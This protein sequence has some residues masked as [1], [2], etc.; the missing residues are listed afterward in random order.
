MRMLVFLGLCLG[1]A[2]L[3][4]CGNSP[5]GAKAELPAPQVTVA[6]PVEKM[7]R[8]YEYATGRFVPLES[9]EVRARVS[10]YL[11][12][13]KFKPGTEVKKNDI[14]FE[15]D[16]DPFK[17]DLDKAKANET[18]A[19]ADKASAEADLVRSDAK[20]VFAKS[21]FA[22]QDEAFKKGAGSQKDLD[23]AKG[24]LDESTATVSANKAKIQLATGRISEAKADIKKADLNLGYC[25]IRAPIDGLIGDKLVTEGNLVAGGSGNTTLLTTILSVDK[26]DV[27]FDVDEGTI[28]RIRKAI[29]QKKLVVSQDA[30]PADAGLGT[31]AKEFPLH[32]K[33]EFF[34][35]QLDVKTGTQRLKARFENPLIDP[36]RR[37][38]TVGMYARV[39]VPIGEPVMSTLVPD[40]AFGSDQGIRYLY[41]IGPENKAVRYDAITGVQEGDMRVVESV[42]VPGEKPRPLTKADAIIVGGMQRVRPGMTV[43]PKE[44]M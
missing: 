10:G 12:A 23:K 6:P 17:A 7:V 14:L 30:I 1:A 39:R 18:I 22:R 15:I 24:D 42:S 20:W 40:E 8:R 43:D 4:G 29:E 37:R 32:G 13:I 33:I 28:Q 31:D 38:L 34:N 9:V 16:P 25:T 5:G 44:K 36:T 19:T 27:G 41:L 26:L 35:N 2:G 3:A 11:N 21:E